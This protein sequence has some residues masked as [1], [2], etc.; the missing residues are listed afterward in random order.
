MW[1]STFFKKTSLP[2]SPLT[3]EVT[4][5]RTSSRRVEDPYTIRCPAFT[6]SMR[7][8]S[9]ASSLSYRSFIIRIS[10]FVIFP[11]KKASRTASFFFMI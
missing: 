5:L 1:S 10:S 2:R 8:F 6:T 9:S 4:C 7:L 3:M 11:E